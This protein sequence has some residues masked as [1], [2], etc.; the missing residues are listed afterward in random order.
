MFTGEYSILPSPLSCTC[1]VFPEFYL[2]G[3]GAIISS[4]LFQ[5]GSLLAVV[6]VLQIQ[7]PEVAE[8][9]NQ[10]D[11][12]QCKHK[13]VLFSYVFFQ[14]FLQMRLFWWKSPQNLS[15]PLG[16]VQALCQCAD[17]LAEKGK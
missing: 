1:M 16:G 7:S 11:I 3:D 8:S 14:L 4:Q 6:T 13:S 10:S 17:N 12:Y 9:S 15:P 2:Q 5:S